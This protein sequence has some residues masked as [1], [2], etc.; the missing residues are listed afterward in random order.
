MKLSKAQVDGI[1]KR[2]AEQKD[3]KVS[4]EEKLEDQKEAEV[5]LKM[6]GFKLNKTT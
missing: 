2:V 1:N 5:L 4:S 3:W 6:A